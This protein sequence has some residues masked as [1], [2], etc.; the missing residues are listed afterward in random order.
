G[1]GAIE[2]RSGAIPPNRVV[3]PFTERD[4]T[5]KQPNQ[6]QSKWLILETPAIVD[7]SELRDAAPFT[8]GGTEYNIEFHLKPTGAQAFGD[9]TGKN[10]GKYLA[11][12]LNGEVKSAPV[13]KGQIFD[14]GQI[15]GKFTKQ[16]A[17]DLA[18]TLKSGALPAPITYQEERTVG[19][20]LGADSIRSGVAASLG[21]LGLVVVFMLF[22]YR[23]AG[24]NA[25]I[26]LILN[27]VLTMAALIM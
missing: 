17:D 11:I 15:E 25:V 13:I 10:I 5:Q 22:Y 8:R 1:E 23:G 7:G 9:W 27:M 18:L 19:P 20:S 2:A 21:G 3:L 12:V 16:S 6:Q 24:I 26:A 14:T 4:D